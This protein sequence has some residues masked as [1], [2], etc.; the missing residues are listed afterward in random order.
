MDKGEA[1]NNK[2]DV[3]I[4]AVVLLDCLQSSP[5]LSLPFFSCDCFLFPWQQI[6]V[7]FISDNPP[8]PVT[9]SLKPKTQATW[10]KNLPFWHSST[11]M[12]TN[13]QKGRNGP[14]RSM[15]QVQ[16]RSLQKKAILK[17]ALRS[18]GNP[19]G[20]L[21]VL[22][23]ALGQRLEGVESIDAFEHLH[24]SDEQPNLKVSRGQLKRKGRKAI[25][26]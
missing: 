23:D 3:K 14:E 15:R 20:N 6:S 21:R 16:R 1:L 10:C 18:L 11:K 22:C 4:S 2:T 25:Y 7:F 26:I 12:W 19:G 5:S 13:K 24:V 17:R 9:N 8:L